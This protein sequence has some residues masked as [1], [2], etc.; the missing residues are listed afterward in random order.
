MTQPTIVAI[1]SPTNPA[2]RGIVRL[3]GDDLDNVLAAMGVVIDPA[4]RFPHRF[5][6]EI[7]VGEPLGRVP[8]E[9]LLWPGRRSYTGLPSAELHT[10]GSSPVLSSLMTC[11]ISAGARP[12]RAGEFTL[13][14]FL[15]GRLDL[16]QAEAVLG[17]VEAEQ[18]AVLQ[19]ALRQLAGNLS[20]PLMTARDDLLNLLADIEAG[21]DFVDEDIEFVT[22]RQ[23]RDRLTG[24]LVQIE[25][26][27]TQLTERRSSD[28]CTRVALCGLPNAGKSCLLNALV[29]LPTA[30]VS[31]MAGTT[32]DTVEAEIALNGQPFRILD[33]AGIESAIDGSVMAAAQTLG[34]QAMHDA[35]IRLWCVDPT[36][37]NSNDDAYQSADEDD[38]AKF[39]Q[40]DPADVIEALEH[41]R[42]ELI[43]AN[44]ALHANRASS[45]DL[46][47]AT[48]SD[49]WDANIDLG[50]DWIAV[51]GLNGAGLDQLR[52]QLLDYA[53]R[54]DL[55]ELGGVIGT[56]ARCHRSLQL[57]I[58]TLHRATQ[59]IDAHAGHELL[60]GELRLAVETLGEV[61]GAIVTDDILDRVFSRFCIG[62]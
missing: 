2:P 61:T 22:D 45:L 25:S 53:Q 24:A 34:R 11:A 37:R 14:A 36:D 39:N 19:S 21:L 31:P 26:A 8:V 44:D 46:F 4:K 29:G 42:S 30:I 51:S 3:S 9:V 10:I 1:A 60:A 17:V 52:K 41:G 16:I 38:N 49:R 12:A 50:E 47:L 35:D 7:D 20:T 6:S 33:T 57:A 48:K 58:S 15:A 62:K 13:L 5:D 32:R 23:I 43:A 18:P 59:M 27:Q 56:S 40:V 54:T 55:A 28:A